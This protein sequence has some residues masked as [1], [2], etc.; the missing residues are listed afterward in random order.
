MKTN[1]IEMSDFYKDNSFDEGK[2]AE[3]LSLS[4]WDFESLAKISNPT[5]PKDLRDSSLLESRLNGL[6]SAYGQLNDMQI[7]GLD[8]GQAKPRDSVERRLGPRDRTDKLLGTGIDGRGQVEVLEFRNLKNSYRNG[9]GPGAAPDATLIISKNFDPDKPV[10]VVFFNH[11]HFGSG[12]DWSDKARLKEKMAAAAPNTIM[13]I[14]EWQTRPGTQDNARAASSQANFYRNQLQEIFDRTPQLQGKT[15]DN[16]RSISI[17]AHSAGVNAAKSQLDD[18]GFGGRVT[19][20]TVLDAMYVPDAYDSWVRSNAGDLASGRKQLTVV[21]RGDHESTSG[22][23][24]RK[25]MER[26][27]RQAL[28]R[29]QVP[30]SAYDETGSNDPSVRRSGVHFTYDADHMGLPSRHIARVLEDDRRRRQQFAQG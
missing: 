17:V 26:H 1:R 6:A 10:S 2:A 23:A 9:G 22:I 3:R 19:S 4:A 24:R 5:N 20:V 21:Y 15:I 27:V 16:I 25:L 13:V 30:D 12:K 11:G 8:C 18:N 7:T 14:P 28:G 29:H